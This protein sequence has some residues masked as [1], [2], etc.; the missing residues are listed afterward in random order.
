MQM[1]VNVQRELALLERMS[2]KELKIRYAEVFGDETRTGNRVWLVR[3]IAWRI[4]ANAMGGLSER[5]FK[6]ATELSNESDLRTIPPKLRGSMVKDEA[7]PPTTVTQTV[8]FG[9]DNRIPLPGTVLSRQY[10][11]RTIHVRV[12]QR[13]FEFEGEV[14]RSLSAV[15][16]VI[17]GTHCNGFRFFQLRA[18]PLQ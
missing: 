12:L 18:E 8:V 4:Q 1:T 9:H 6:R 2:V 5:A 3:R 7:G 13:G 11:G 15:A 17:S 10:K 16:K 14:Y